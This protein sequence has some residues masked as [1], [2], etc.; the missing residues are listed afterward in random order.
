M[1]RTD[2]AKQEAMKKLSEEQ[3]RYIEE[4][5]DLHYSE[6]D[7]MKMSDE[8][9]YGLIN[10]YKGFTILFQELAGC[11]FSYTTFTKKI[12]PAKGFASIN[13]VWEKKP[14]SSEKSD[15]LKRVCYLEER[16]N[17]LESTL[18]S[19]TSSDN[20][21]FA[22]I[23]IP[24]PKAGNSKQIRTQVMPDVWEI[25]IR[26]IEKNSLSV[27]QFNTMAIQLFMDSVKEKRIALNFSLVLPEQAEQETIGEHE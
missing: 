26:F 6:D 7:C 11:N 5:K 9:I 12:L 1:R 13:G 18:K 10:R 25:W 27:A 17:L 15:I 22:P 24:I 16:V 3:K 8:E 20:V 14:N 21:G 19:Q 23:A 4:A 2:I